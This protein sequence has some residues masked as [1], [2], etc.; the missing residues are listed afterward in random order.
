MTKVMLQVGVLAFCVSAVLFGAQDLPLFTIIARAFIVFM[1]VVFA[2]VILLMVATHMKRTP[3]QRA[4]SVQ[5][6]EDH[7]AQAQGPASPSSQTPAAA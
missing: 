4:A 3:P 2:Q 7:D 5:N 6:R 1:A